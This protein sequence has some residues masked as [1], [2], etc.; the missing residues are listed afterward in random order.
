MTSAKDVAERLQT[1]RRTVYRLVE[2]GKLEA[3]N[4]GVGGKRILRIIP[5]SVDEFLLRN[6]DYDC[7]THVKRNKRRC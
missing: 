5:D 3:V 6:S 2:S 4:V 1:S 7:T